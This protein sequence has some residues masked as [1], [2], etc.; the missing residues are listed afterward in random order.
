MP[1]VDVQADDADFWDGEQALD[2]DGICPDCAE[3]WDLCECELHAQCGRWINGRLGRACTLAGTEFCD[4]ECPM[5][6]VRSDK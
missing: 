2:D 1:D 5:R 4:F 3:I 6:D